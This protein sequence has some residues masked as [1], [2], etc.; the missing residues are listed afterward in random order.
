M[1]L[2]MFEQVL[3]WCLIINISLLALSSSALF[4]ARNPIL[5][6]HSKLIG[7]NPEQLKPEYLRFIANYKLLILV[8]NFAPWLSLQLI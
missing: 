5:R 7:L 8:F 1:S 3:Q 2:I 6:I 4:F